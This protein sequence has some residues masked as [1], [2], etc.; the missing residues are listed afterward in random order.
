MNKQKS[1]GDTLSSDSTKQLKSKSS[2]IINSNSSH[3]L[4]YKIRHNITSKPKPV[5]M[6]KMT[7]S[8]KQLKK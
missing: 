2:K 1:K 6:N 8:D 5:N 7:A 4:E 3:E